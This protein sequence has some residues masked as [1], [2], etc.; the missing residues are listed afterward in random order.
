MPVAGRKAAVAAVLAVA[1]VR[2]SSAL[3]P[4]VIVPGDGSN[5]IEAKLDKPSTVSWTCSK[6]ADWFRLWLDTSN[7]LLA[8][9]CWADNIKLLYDEEKNELTNNLGV[10]T[11]VPGWGTTTGFEELDPAIPFHGSKVFLKMVQQ[12]VGAGY[13]RNVTLRG[14]PYDFRYAPP[15]KVGAKFQDDLRQ[16]IEDTSKMNG[17]QKVALISHSMGCLQVLSL[18][19]NQPP[20]WKDQYIEKWMPLSGPYG[21]AGKEIRLHASGDNQGIPGVSSLSIRE[22]QRSYETNFWLAPVPK[23]WGDRVVVT[24]PKRSYTVQDYDAFFEDVGFAAGKKIMRRIAGLTGPT[25]DLAPG[26][27]VLCLYSLGV[28][29]PV[30]FN[31]PDGDFDKTPEIKNG[32]GD[33]TVNDFSLKLCDNWAQTDPARARTQVF[34]GI[35]HSGM[36]SDDGVL[37]VIKQELGL[38]ATDTQAITV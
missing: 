21:G 7:L 17:G 36:L 3:T 32:D 12:L 5:Q 35:D 15:S 14:A 23:W 1:A 10:E 27:P 6:T 38:K 18:M 16:L 9:S 26:V 37:A 29:T 33:G 30:S 8:T 34:H 19:R 28:Q 24:T 11:R 20:A 2:S 25:A 22:E 31:Y 4:V 13:E